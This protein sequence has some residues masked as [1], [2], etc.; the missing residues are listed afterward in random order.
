MSQTVTLLFY[1]IPSS[2]TP[3]LI[4]ESLVNLSIKYLLFS[5]LIPV[6]VP[7][8]NN[9]EPLYLSFPEFTR[10]NQLSTL[11]GFVPR[12]TSRKTCRT[13][14]NFVSTLSVHLLKWWLVVALTL[15]S[16]SRLLVFS[17]I[18]DFFILLVIFRNIPFGSP[19]FRVSFQSSLLVISYK[20]SKL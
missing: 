12:I 18:L 4:S 16:P 6:P 19:S 1:S 11:M 13:L 8:Q 15:L 3:L 10:S 20:K 7:L 17:F 2:T 5:N 9:W 14:T